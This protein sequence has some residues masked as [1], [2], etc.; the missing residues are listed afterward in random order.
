[1][2]ALAAGSS[3]GMTLTVSKLLLFAACVLFVIAALAAG[4]VLATGAWPFGFGGL[5]AWAL[6]AAL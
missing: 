3:R 6:A 1:M 4:G 2:E 5:A